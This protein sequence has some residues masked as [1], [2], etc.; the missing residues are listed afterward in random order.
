MRKMNF[1]QPAVP[2][3]DVGGPPS[4]ALLVVATIACSVWGL[5]VMLQGVSP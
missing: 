1:E 2:N 5:L 3:R 4:L